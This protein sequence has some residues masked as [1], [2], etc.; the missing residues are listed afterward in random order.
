MHPISFQSTQVQDALL[1]DWSFTCNFQFSPATKGEASD[2]Q[3]AMQ[4]ETEV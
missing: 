2:S 4:L 1:V 3:T